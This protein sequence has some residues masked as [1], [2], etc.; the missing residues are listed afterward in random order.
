MFGAEGGSADQKLDSNTVDIDKQRKCSVSLEEPCTPKR[1]RMPIL[2]HGLPS[3]ETP[4][5][6]GDVQDALSA[7]SAQEELTWQT[8]LS[9]TKDAV[10][11]ALENT[12]DAANQLPALVQ[13]HTNSNDADNH[14]AETAYSQTLKDT[15]KHD[16][17][18]AREL[19]GSLNATA[20][21]RSTRLR[22]QP[23]PIC[24]CY[25]RQHCQCTS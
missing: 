12:K 4:S 23:Q 5:F 16:A 10:E 17:K 24:E 15:T 13:S 7:G 25:I 19:G 9:R 2:W 11:I 3:P 6:H 1:K 14:D 8:S 20:T 22:T 18:L 21:R